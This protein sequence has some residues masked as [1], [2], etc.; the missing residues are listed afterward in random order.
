VLGFVGLDLGSE[1]S[2]LS[3]RLSNH[4]TSAED[5]RCSLSTNCVC[6][7]TISARRALLFSMSLD[8]P[9][10]RISTSHSVA[11]DLSESWGP[12]FVEGPEGSGQVKPFAISALAAAGY[13]V[14]WFQLV[15]LFK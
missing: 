15:W 13:D 5:K 4:C 11:V 2:N 7:A 14:R 1:L 10:A 8:G 12:G 9:P 3:L 6:S